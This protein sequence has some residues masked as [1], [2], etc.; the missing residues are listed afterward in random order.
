MKKEMELQS[1]LWLFIE[2]I[3]FVD[4]LMELSD[5]MIFISRSKLGLSIYGT[6]GI[7]ISSV[8]KKKKDT[9]N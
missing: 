6:L 9:A 8:R 1:K 7:K 2:T 3:L 5:F 4:F